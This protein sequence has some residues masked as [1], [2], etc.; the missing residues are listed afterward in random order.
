MRHK[1]GIIMAE[2]GN[3]L[4]GRGQNDHS[5]ASRWTSRPLQATRNRQYPVHILGAMRE[6]RDQ[7]RKSFYYIFFLGKKGRERGFAKSG[8]VNYTL[9]E[10]HHKRPIPFLVPQM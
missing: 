6:A 3:I 2:K 10:Y 1:R 8:G 4:S 9:M 5:K 7:S